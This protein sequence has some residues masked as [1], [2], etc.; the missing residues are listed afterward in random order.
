MDDDPPELSTTILFWVQRW[1]IPK[2]PQSFPTT[3][4]ARLQLLA[5]TVLCPTAQAGAP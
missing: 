2:H 3:V 4:L 1:M 5:S